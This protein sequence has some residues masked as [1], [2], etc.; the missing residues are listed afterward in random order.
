MGDLEIEPYRVV[1]VGAVAAKIWTGARRTT[2]SIEMLRNILD[3]RDRPCNWDD[4]MRAERLRRQR[5]ESELF[6]KGAYY[7]TG[8][9]NS[10]LEVFLGSNVSSRCTNK[11]MSRI[12]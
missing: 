6:I 7:M 1:Q 11:L 8:I 3:R 5:A 9:V 4:E 2:T 10:R 12:R